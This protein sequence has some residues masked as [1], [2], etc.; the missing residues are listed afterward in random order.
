MPIW[1]RSKLGLIAPKSMI[2]ICTTTAG[3]KE[4][5]VAP[6]PSPLPGEDHNILQATKTWLLLSAVQRGEGERFPE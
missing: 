1:E 3:D 6:L 5:C 2:G 4:R